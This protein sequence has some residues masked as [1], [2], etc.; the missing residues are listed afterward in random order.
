MFEVIYLS[1][2]ITGRI[3]QAKTE[4]AKAQA[5][6]EAKGYSVVNP[7]AMC[8]KLPLNLPHHVYMSV[9]MAILP[10]CDTL[11]IVNDISNSKGA[12]IEIEWAKKN[13]LD[14]IGE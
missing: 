8:E 1:G 14:V 13:N 10:Y 3:E 7:F 9:C 5:E 6:W 4:F 2:A 12:K 11:V